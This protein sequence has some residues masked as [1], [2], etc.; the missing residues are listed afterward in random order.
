MSLE[1][2]ARAPTTAALQG[3]EGKERGALP[4]LLPQKL[5]SGNLRKPRNAPCN[6]TQHFQVYSLPESEPC[7]K[8]YKSLNLKKGST[9]GIHHEQCWEAH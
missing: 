4:G 7:L 5:S 9:P 8:K 6:S 1:G 3:R 2:G